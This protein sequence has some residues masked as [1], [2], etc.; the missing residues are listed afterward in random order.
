GEKTIVKVTVGRAA[1]AAAAGKEVDWI[2]FRDPFRVPFEGEPAFVTTDVPVTQAAFSA[3]GKVVAASSADGRV[4]VLDASTG[5]NLLT[6]KAHGVRI[7]LLKFFPDRKILV[8]VGDNGEVKL[9]DTTTGKEVGSLDLPIKPSLAALASDAKTLA[10][11]LDGDRVRIWDVT[12]GKFISRLE[13]MAPEEALAFS[14]DG[15]VLA[16]SSPTKV[17]LWDARTGASLRGFD[18]Q[19]GIVPDLSSWGVRHDNA[20]A[21]SPDGKLIASSNGQQ[22]IR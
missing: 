1:E 18:V 8:T 7:R 12:T 13:G 10:A 11:S 17:S 16:G 5:K 20:L 3:D 6:I 14:P 19:D 21:F 4:H 22:V 2:G 15:A 9:W